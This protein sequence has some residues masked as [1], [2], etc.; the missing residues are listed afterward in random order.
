[1]K[2]ITI[3]IILVSIFAVGIVSGAI[4]TSLLNT[5]VSPKTLN[6]Y[7]S[8]E[9]EI[10]RVGDD[11]TSIRGRRYAVVIIEDIEIYDKEGKSI[12]GIIPEGTVIPTIQVE[13]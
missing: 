5:K 13:G 2:N 6:D 9:R 10:G 8:L 7:P 1:M 3:A 12:V 4:G 11:Y